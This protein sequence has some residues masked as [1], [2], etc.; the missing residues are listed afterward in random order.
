[1]TGVFF[2]FV[3][4]FPQRWSLWPVVRGRKMVAGSLGHR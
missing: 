4:R 3:H 1:M 2:V